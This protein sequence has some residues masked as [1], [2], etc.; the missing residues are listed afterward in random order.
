MLTPVTRLGGVIA[1]EFPRPLAA[2]VV[3]LAEVILDPVTLVV[4][5]WGMGGP[6]GSAKETGVA[7]G[8]REW[9][10]LRNERAQQLVS[11]QLQKE[12][13]AARATS[14]EETKMFVEDL[15]G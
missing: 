6:G 5:R 3:D 14:A 2:C 7:M 11:R 12:L 1:S 13:Q 4:V 8:S 10:K 9:L 15:W